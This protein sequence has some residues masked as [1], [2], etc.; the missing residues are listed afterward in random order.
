MKED[1]DNIYLQ[2]KELVKYGAIMANLSLENMKEE[3][4]EDKNEIAKLDKL[5]KDLNWMND[6]LD[7]LKEKESSV[8]ED[9]IEHL[10]MVLSVGESYNKWMYK[11][12][13]ELMPI[14]ENIKNNLEAKKGESRD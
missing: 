8:D 11:Y 4:R 5:V 10:D 12:T 1:T 6:E 14:L 7:I 2:C 13:A 3:K 9:N